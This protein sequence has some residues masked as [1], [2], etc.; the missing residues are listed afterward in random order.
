[1]ELTQAVFEEED[2]EAGEKGEDGGIGGGGGN[3]AGT[4]GGKRPMKLKMKRYLDAFPFPY[5]VVVRRV[6]DLP[7]VLATAL[8]GWFAEVVDAG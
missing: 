5:Y 1:M 7:G 6:E 8:K 3:G 2:D 4:G